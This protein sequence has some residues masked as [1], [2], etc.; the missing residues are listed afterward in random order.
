M[1]K[2]KLKLFLVTAVASMIIFPSFSMGAETRGAPT[3]ADCVEKTG[4]SD[5]ECA[6]MINNFKN[7]RP[8]GGEMGSR[9]SGRPPM[10]KNPENI[11]GGSHPQNI[12]MTSID[13]RI[14]NAQ[15]MKDGRKE[16][17]VRIEERIQKLIDYIKSKGIDTAEIE[18][19][20]ATFKEKADEI[21]SAFDTYIQALKNYK[22]DDSSDNSAK[23]RDARENIRTLSEKLAAFY[24]SS[25]RES[26]K[27]LIDQI[28]D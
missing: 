28:E 15:K 23:I 11:R 5:S 16:R 1:K 21:L 6:E 9:D 20:S 26:I 17:F 10:G 22:S 25:I 4:K 2:R 24:R 27:T 8:P 14:E 7:R 12:N 19:N 3:V 18:N 13:N